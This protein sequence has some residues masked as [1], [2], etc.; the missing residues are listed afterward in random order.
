[1]RLV[2]Q[3]VKKAEVRLVGDRVTG[4]IGKGLFILVGFGHD[5]TRED[6]ELFAAKLIKLRIMSDSKDKLNLSIKDVQ[7]EILV[8]SQFTLYGDVSG[9]NRPSFIRAAK[10]SH[11]KELYNHFIHLLRNF[12]V[13]VETG[14]F[15]EYMKIEASLDGPVT[16]LI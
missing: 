15:G 2:V 9:G 6:V 16:I 11:A 7:G 8:V 1:M 14:S 10:P 13:K 3:R 5:D 4:K 12:G